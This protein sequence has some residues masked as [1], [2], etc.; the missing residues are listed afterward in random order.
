MHY[1]KAETYASTLTRWNGLEERKD[2]SPYAFFCVADK[3]LSCTPI[4]MR[5]II[6]CECTALLHASRASC[7]TLAH[8]RVFARVARAA[9]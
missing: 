9:L 5:D 3:A 6:C 4:T 1:P 8:L 2:G 7:A